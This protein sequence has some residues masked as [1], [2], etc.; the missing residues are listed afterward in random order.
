MPIVKNICMS[1][2]HW[3]ENQW[4]QELLEYHTTWEN[5]YC[6]PMTETIPDW[7][8]KL[9]EAKNRQKLIL[10]ERRQKLVRRS[11]LI[12]IIILLCTALV[13]LLWKR[14]NRAR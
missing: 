2:L 3:S 5:C 7:K 11:S 8:K 13:A 14:S 1:E 10:P 12:V 6:L 4:Q 9:V